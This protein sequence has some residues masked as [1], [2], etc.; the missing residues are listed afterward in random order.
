MNNVSEAIRLIARHSE[1]PSNQRSLRMLKTILISIIMLLLIQSLSL[2]QPNDP[3]LSDETTLGLWHLETLQ[4]HFDEAVIIADGN[5]MSFNSVIRSQ[6]GNFLVGGTVGIEDTT[7]FLLLKLQPDG[8][9]IW[10]SNFKLENANGNI[11]HDLTEKEDGTII[12][13]GEVYGFRN[14]IYQGWMLMTNNE[15][16]LVTA[17]DVFENEGFAKTV[18]FDHN[19]NILVGGDVDG[20]QISKFTGG[21]DLIWDYHNQASMC[22]KIVQSSDSCYIAVGYIHQV[23]DLFGF[24]SKL[25]SNGDVEWECQFGERGRT[26]EFL[27]VVEIDNGYL[28]LGYNTPIGSHDGTDSNIW[29]VTFDVDG[30]VTN[31]VTINRDVFGRCIGFDIIEAHDGN[32][33][34]TG[35][36]FDN[37]I[38][39]GIPLLK[40]NSDLEIISSES[41]FDVDL[42]GA[43]SIIS[44]PDNSFTIFGGINEIDLFLHESGLMLITSTDYSWNFDF[45]DNAN[46]LQSEGIIGFCD[47]VFGDALDL[48][49]REGGIA[50][51]PDN[52]SL[53]PEQFRLEAW[54]RMDP[55]IPHEGAIVSKLIEEGFPS[56]Q[57]YANSI[58]GN[59]GFS[60][61]TE[62]GID[63]VE[64]NTNLN[65]SDWHYIAGDFDGEQIRLIWEGNLVG[66]EEIN[67]PVIYSEGPLVVGGDADYAQSDLQFYGQIDEVM[68]SNTPFEEVKVPTERGEIALTNFSIT[69]ISPNPF[70][71]ST[72]ISYALPSSCEVRLTIHD[73]HGREITVLQD[74]SQTAGLK[75]ILW[76]AGNQPSGL[77]LC[78][79]ESAGETH[80]MKL[81]LAR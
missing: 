73:L 16:E 42:S 19:G 50:F 59:V 68:F 25:N 43:S 46:N 63:F 4:P 57:L 14:G 70:N 31:D 17:I 7:R 33:I 28:C 62:A 51:A 35:S 44:N 27:S 23:S 41:Y 75:K 12:M 56:F 13:V 64:I 32:F 6:D 52:E 67:S 34:I 81:V 78:R 29:L 26:A 37:Q 9:I 15:G 45:S 38:A 66:T 36:I 8:R 71:S 10:R 55:D 48:S 60:I 58:Q 3:F 22:H 77:Y 69:S 61:T 76:N 79:L 24:I 11:C 49:N 47:G 1:V 65:N 20:F 40:I 2:S 72:T 5:P 53:H 39:D 54:F 30:N 74:G 18:L 80:N 21:G